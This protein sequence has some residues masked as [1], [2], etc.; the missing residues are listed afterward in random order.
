[1]T[2]SLLADDI[3]KRITKLA[4]QPKSAKGAVA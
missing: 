2:I 3:W 4:R 1:M